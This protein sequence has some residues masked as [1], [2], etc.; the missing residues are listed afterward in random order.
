[1]RLLMIPVLFL[2]AKLLS[3]FLCAV[4]G[5]A[6][7]APAGETPPKPSLLSLS[8]RSN[9]PTNLFYL[10][11]ITP[12]QPI[13]LSVETQNRTGSAGSIQ[14][15]WR[16]E[17]YWGKEVRSDRSKSVSIAPNATDH[18]F[19]SFHREA[20]LKNRTGYYTFRITASKGREKAEAV[21]TF[22]VIPRPVGGLKANSMFGVSTPQVNGQTLAALQKIGAKWLRTSAG[23][24]WAEG[25][26]KEKGTFDWD[27][28]DR[29]STEARAHG[30]SVVPVLGTPP[31]WAKMTG[32]DGNTL[33][34]PA[35]VKDH[36]DYA[37]A[38]VARY[39][40]DSRYWEIWDS[41]TV[42]GPTW[43]HTAQ[44]Y[45]ELMKATY[46]AAK[47][48]NPSVMI[49]GTGGGVS[50][51]QDVALMPGAEVYGVF[52]AVSARANLSG[53]P[54]EEFFAQAELASLLSRKYNR[55]QVWLTANLSKPVESRQ[56]AQYVPRSYVLAA[57]AGASH[58]NWSPLMDRDQGLFGP[59]LTP[60][61]AAVAYAVAASHL[62]D[63]IFVRDLW[64][65]SRRIY[66]AI[67]KNDAG[68]KIAAV[69]SVGERGSLTVDGAKEIRAYDV[70]GGEIGNRRKDALEVPLNEEVVYLT[71]DGDQAVFIEAVRNARINGISPVEIVAKPFLASVSLTPP[72]RVQ[73]TNMLNRPIDGNVES[74]APK[75]WKLADSKVPFGPLNPGESV[76]VELPVRQTAV[77][78]TNTYPVT[79]TAESRQRG[80]SSFFVR[81]TGPEWRVRREQTLFLAGAVPGSPVIDGDLSD[82]SDALPVQA[83]TPEFISSFVPESWRASWTPGNLSAQVFT[84]YD[85]ENFYVAARVI[86][87]YQNNAGMAQNPYN[88]SYYGDS[89]QLS[90][91]P[92]QV[93]E[94]TKL[95]SP[96]APNAN[97]GV[98]YDTDYEYSLAHTPKGPEAL[99][100]HT[101]RSG[102]VTPYPTNPSTGLGVADAVRL[103]VKRDD[104]NEVTIY[105]AAIPWAELS[106]LPRDRSFH[107]AFKLNDRD[108]DEVV[109]WMNSAAGAGE[110]RGNLLTF[111][112]SWQYATA[113]LSD[114]T[115]LGK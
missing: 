35:N 91:W 62:E 92:A 5:E 60:T 81:I 34:V 37:A 103:S 32:P 9:E 10:D 28:F 6:H 108:R 104:V 100:L 26:P 95:K 27:R 19:L 84:Q 80:V 8:I 56:L 94:T 106:D 113:N 13:T 109:G 65:H 69:W 111:S 70:L 1:M 29:I 14:Y 2:L 61:P 64:P 41:P 24:S 44:A 42:M 83:E 47:R 58:L 51:L 16:L 59:G 53:P 72:I 50:H 99:R 67:F 90:F 48:A 22:G 63:T 77:S 73:V 31:E 66:G 33:N 110:V 12:S 98:I 96:T 7:G 23:T 114:W 46:S 105:E 74:S 76:T 11:A 30:L 86:D 49:L 79:V 89:L 112:P 107:F 15:R 75:G 78:P 21:T 20:D 71:S 54:E 82:W 17:D 101:P 88:F 4:A 39:A 55:D 93:T 18:L 36:A 97:R 85:D 57:I 43:P 102:Y 3:L 25:E 40:R 52:D 38:A 45:R 115:L 68:R 87:N